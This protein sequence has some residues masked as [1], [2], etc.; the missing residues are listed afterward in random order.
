MVS[1][2]SCRE[3]GA[4]PRSRGEHG[5]PTGEGSADL[6][7]SPL[8]RGAPADRLD[9]EVGMGAH[10]R[11]RGEHPM[12]NHKTTETNGSSPLTR[13]ALSARAARS[14]RTGLIPA[15][16]G[17]TRGKCFVFSGR[18]AHPRSRGEHRGLVKLLDLDYGSSP[19]TRGARGCPVLARWSCGLIPAHAGSTA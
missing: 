6:G 7:S 18:R 10:P 16:A 15:H 8:T 11:S 5:E 14:T 9:K 1:D 3:A 17:S 13:G 4:H 12:G 2:E 19:L